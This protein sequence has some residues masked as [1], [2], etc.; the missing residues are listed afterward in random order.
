M[1]HSKYSLLSFGALKTFLLSGE[2]KA[3][4]VFGEKWRS[5]SPA[6]RMRVGTFFP[7]GLDWNNWKIAIA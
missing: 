3:Q 4:F 2:C 6:E 5:L 1:T 7:V